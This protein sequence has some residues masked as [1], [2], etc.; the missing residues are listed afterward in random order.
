MWGGSTVQSKTIIAAGFYLLSLA[1]KE[2][3]F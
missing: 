2:A 1:V 3:D